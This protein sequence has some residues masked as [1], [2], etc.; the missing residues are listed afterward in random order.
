MKTNKQKV[1]IVGGGFAGVKTAMELS[2]DRRFAVTLLSETEALR[3]YPSLYHTATGGTKAVSSL[4]L[5]EILDK[6][7]LKV[8]KG[9]AVR[10]DRALKR[11]ITDD[12]AEYTYDYLVLSLGVV[13]NYFNIP[14]LKELSYGIK[15]LE[16]AEELKRHLHKQILSD[17]KPDINYV[18][19]GGGPSGV[20]L[21][22]VLGD[23]VEYICR[24]HGI[25]KKHF[26]VDLVESAPRLVARMPRDVSRRIKNQLRRKGVK[27]HL[28]SAV[29]GQTAEALTVNGKA[30]RSHTVVWTAGVTNNPFFSENNFQLSSAGKVRVN[31]Y[32]QAEPS[33]FVAGDN[34]DTPYSGMAQTAIYDAEYIAKALV[35]IVG[36][37]RAP[38]PYY[39]K[40][41]IYVMPAGPNWAAVVW[42]KLR[43]YGYGGWFM[44]RSADLLGYKDYEPWLQAG[45]RWISEYEREDICDTCQPQPKPAQTLAT[46]IGASRR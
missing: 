23:Y 37:K 34:A 30:L 14:G 7:L 3:Y 8:A 17:R 9:K 31:Q 24:K 16:D 10:L 43:F 13:T 32:L 11:V 35:D 5:N 29:Q 6:K 26:H 25:E 45:R 2:K 36:N 46:P 42:G 33:I 27:I 21:A 38:E 22:G 44:R 19:V 12:G 18:V 1:L 40:K 4:P 28:K 15:S 20:E 41:P 39:A